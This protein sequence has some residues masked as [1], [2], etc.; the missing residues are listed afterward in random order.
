[1]NS[2]F[3]S[4]TTRSLSILIASLF[5]MSFAYG[6]EKGT[7]YLYDVPPAPPYQEAQVTIAISLT[8]GCALA[9]KN[10]IGYIIKIEEDKV[11]DYDLVLQDEN[12]VRHKCYIDTNLT[13]N[14]DLS[15]L[16]YTLIPGNKVEMK[17]QYCGSGG[18][19]YVM[20]INNLKRN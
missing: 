11:A 15:W 8:D 10:L 9:K 4:C 6:Q 14:Y 17:V 18:F 5:F 13:S 12:G 3:L 7:P 20:E 16:K 2:F 19:I 1:M